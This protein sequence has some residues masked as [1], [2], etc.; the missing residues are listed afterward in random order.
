MLAATQPPAFSPPIAGY[1]THGVKLSMGLLPDMAHFMCQRRENQL[2]RP[3]GEIVRIEREFMDSL[4]INAP[5]KPK[6][7][8]ISPSVGMPLKVTKTCGK[9]PANSSLLKKSYALLK[10]LIFF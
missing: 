4:L 7:R 10:P 2:V 9:L 6:R 5:F 1:G 3:S 8:K